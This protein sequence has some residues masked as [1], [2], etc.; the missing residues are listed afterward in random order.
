MSHL[1]A[2]ATVYVWGMV[3]LIVFHMMKAGYFRGSH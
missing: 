3:V 2:L 1:E